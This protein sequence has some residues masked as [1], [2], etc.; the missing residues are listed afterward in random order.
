MLRHT[1]SAL[2]ILL[3]SLLLA[4]C[5]APR[6]PA[7]GAEQADAAA[8][9]EAAS[10]SASSAAASASVAAA[11]SAAA[12]DAASGK[13]AARDVKVESEL[14]EFHYAYP[15][16]AGAIPALAKTLDDALQ[17]ERTKLETQA[18]EARTA[19]KADGYPYH[20][21]AFDKTWKVVTENPKWLSLSAQIY[22]FSGGAHGMTVFDTLLWDKQAGQAR[23]PL[24]LF[25]SAAALRGAIQQP[26]CAR[27][28]AERGKRRE[29]PVKRSAEWSENCIDPLESTVILG[30]AN[31]T[32]F[33]RIG[34]LVPPYEA[35]AYAEGAYEITVPVTRQV[36]D[37]VKPAHRGDFSIGR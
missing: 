15:A 4:A 14:M 26:F 33:D 37:A 20:A 11:A 24:S 9:A 31:G 2:A 6:K 25:T 34:I 27:L 5:D 17:A 23:E 21:Y 3:P 32:T 10:A 30:S 22:T 12:T 36:L 13:G 18:G 8:S 28:D 35:G 19:A 29:A 1:A 16:A 7:D